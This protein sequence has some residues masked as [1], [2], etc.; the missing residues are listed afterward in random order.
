MDNSTLLKKLE[1][2][3]VTDQQLE[4]CLDVRRGIYPLPLYV[5]NANGKHR[6]SRK[7]EETDSIEGIMLQGHGVILLQPLNI[8]ELAKENPRLNLS[9]LTKAAHRCINEK[10]RLLETNDVIGAEGVVL[11]DL[12]DSN[13]ALSLTISKLRDKFPNFLSG[14]K[15]ACVTEGF[16]NKGNIATLTIHH[17]CIGGEP[18]LINQTD[19]IYLII[20]EDKL[21]C[22]KDGENRGLDCGIGLDGC[23]MRLPKELPCL[24]FTKDDKGNYSIKKNLCPGH[25]FEGIVLRNTIILRKTIKPK[26]MGYKTLGELKDAAKEI[27]P[28]A[29]PLYFDGFAFGSGIV[30]LLLIDRERYQLTAELLAQQGITTMPNIECSLS[31]YYKTGHSDDSS[32]LPLINYG[33]WQGQAN[34]NSIDEIL[35][36]IPR[37]KIDSYVC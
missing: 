23:G 11:S 5:K 31:Y 29:E 37:E 36:A 10:A 1:E 13:S 24:L 34:I 33:W 28:E 20:P 26:D 14:A 18:A 7:P 32:R 15:F 12:I 9:K 4:Y 6:L 22:P 25:T 27:H 35:L 30:D 17:L 8:K 2:L 21:N 19:E 16:E 3:G